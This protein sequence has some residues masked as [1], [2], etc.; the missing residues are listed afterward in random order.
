MRVASR[1]WKKQGNGFSPET[2]RK[3]AVVPTYFG[4]LYQT[5]EQG[6]LS[7]LRALGP[8]VHLPGHT[9]ISASEALLLSRELWKS[10][11]RV[12][13]LWAPR[14]PYL[15]ALYSLRG[16]CQ[17]FSS[18]NGPPFLLLPTFGD[19]VCKCLESNLTFS[20]PL[21]VY[22]EERKMWY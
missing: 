12:L 15:C 13:D 21:P 5:W 7:K 6:S 4:H 14:N 18:F 9:I 3:N 2:S 20:S 16:G 17:L 22:F 19:Q 11:N 10:G 8:D 1:G